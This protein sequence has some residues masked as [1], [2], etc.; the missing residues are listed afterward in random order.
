MRILII[1]HIITEDSYFK[2]L[3][4]KN[5]LNWTIEAIK[6]FC[7]EARS[8]PY[9]IALNHEVNITLVSVLHLAIISCISILS[10]YHQEEITPAL[11]QE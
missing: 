9:L 3:M 6:F 4:V 2:I 10:I 1:T 11:S 7:S 8:F 5:S